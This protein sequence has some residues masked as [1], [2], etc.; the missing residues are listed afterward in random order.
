MKIRLRWIDDPEMMQSPETRAYLGALLSQQL[1]HEVL[2][3]TI[4]ANG[5]RSNDAVRAEIETY[6]VSDD[7]ELR[8]ATYR[9]VAYFADEQAL[10]LLRRRLRDETDPMLRRTLTDM[11][12]LL[13]TTIQL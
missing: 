7:A 11:I 10:T 9:S 4:E 5:R 2:L 3:T 13:E 1:D 6:A 8:R 12:S